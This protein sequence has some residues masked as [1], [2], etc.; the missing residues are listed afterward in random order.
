MGKARRPVACGAGILPAVARAARPGQKVCGAYET[1]AQRCALGFG[2]KKEG[3]RLP[4]PEIHSFVV[5]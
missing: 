2:E 5:S 1:A 4:G 3:G